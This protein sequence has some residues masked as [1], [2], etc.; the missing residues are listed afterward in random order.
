MSRATGAGEGR[1]RP[2]AQSLPFILL[3]AREA[4]MG[5]IR[6]VLNAHGLTEQ[7]WRVLRML[8]ATD[9]EEVTRLAAAAFLH[10]PSLSR[11]LRDLGERGLIQRRTPDSDLRRG[12]VRLT[13]QGAAVIAALEPELAA[14]ADAIESRYGDDRLAE[15]RRLLEAIELA[16]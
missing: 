12:L 6:P 10:A 5:R 14:V 11:I 16:L 4:V 8:S 7:Q 13:P 3:R 2:Y 15:L 9:E 1:L